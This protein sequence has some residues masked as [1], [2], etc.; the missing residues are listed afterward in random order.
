MPDTRGAAVACGNTRPAALAT[1]HGLRERGTPSDGGFRRRTGQG[2]VAPVKGQYDRA[3]KVSGC[4]VRALLLETYGGWSPEAVDEPM[5]PADELVR[6]VWMV[7]M[8][9]TVSVSSS[10]IAFRRRCSPIKVLP[11]PAGPHR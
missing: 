2:Y 3:E 4:D 10:R 6:M 7:E 11:E 9:S 5:M 1:V 8:M